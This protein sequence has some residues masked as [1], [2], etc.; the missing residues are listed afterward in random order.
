M[1]ALR[2][3]SVD[4]KSVVNAKDEVDVDAKAWL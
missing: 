1:L 3:G 4:N 2:I